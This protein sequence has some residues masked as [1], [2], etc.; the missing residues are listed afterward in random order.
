MEQGALSALRDADSILIPLDPMVAKLRDVKP[1]YSATFTFADKHGILRLAKSWE[2]VVEDGSKIVDFNE[3]SQK[4][5]RLDRET[6][7][8]SSL[9]DI[10]L[11][12]LTT[13]FG[14]AFTMEAAQTVEEERIDAALVTFARNLKIDAEAAR[15]H[16]S[17]RPF[18]KF[19]SYVPNA[20]LKSVEQR[21]TY[22][23]GMRDLDYN[24]ELTRFQTTAYGAKDPGSSVG[25]TA[26]QPKVIEP[27]WGVT[28][29]SVEWDTTFAE[30]EQLGIG[31][32]TA[33]GDDSRRWFP[34]AISN[35]DD[36]DERLSFYGLLAKLQE[37]GTLLR[38]AKVEDLMGGMS[39]G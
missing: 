34:K 32:K 35:V 3:I 19:N 31:Q 33:W 37:V 21:I 27:R 9:V 1:L 10:S 6:G 18:V 14:W 23:F 12:D 16:A 30:N 28:V 39:I 26:S 4:W 17:D 2:P 22:R 20:A 8:T 13:S 5:E 36:E 11:N 38:S 29:H 15:R 7:T 25:S 24:V